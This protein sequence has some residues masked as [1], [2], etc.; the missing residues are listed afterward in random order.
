[1]TY[2]PAPGHS[3]S[4]RTWVT[5]GGTAVAVLVVIA[6]TAAVASR[7]GRHVDAAMGAG[8]IPALSAHRP[9]ASAVP[10]ATEQALSSTLLDADVLD[11]IVGTTG[12]MVDPMLTTNRLHT[13][14][15]DKPECGGVW[16]NAAQSVYA[17]SGWQLVQTQHLYTQAVVRHQVNE[18]YQSLVSFAT[19]NAAAQFV[20]KEERSWPACDGRYVT[21]T[22][23]SDQ[24]QTWW[25]ATVSEQAGVLRARSNREGTDGWGCQHALSTRR[26]LVIDVKACGLDIAD[27]A[28]AIANGI[29]SHIH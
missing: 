26:N 9:V 23:F 21:T 25:V 5:L 4:R 7:S 1:M 22:D 16:A 12:L 29:A 13:H 14:T 17:G 3:A 27:E 18:I 2:P 8:T 24:S 20:A 11:S 6:L 28:V 19:A 10:A 15:T